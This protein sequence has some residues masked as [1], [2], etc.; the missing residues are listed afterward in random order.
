MSFEGF[1]K[2][3]QGLH[4]FVVVYDDEEQFLGLYL[5]GE[6]LGSV[7]VTDGVIVGDGPLYHNET[8]LFEQPLTPEQIARHYAASGLEHITFDGTS[9]RLHGEPQ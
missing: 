1:E 2:L 3:S 7:Q 5:D 6:L 9:L 4:H 8:A